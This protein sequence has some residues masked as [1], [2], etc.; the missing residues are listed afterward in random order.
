VEN[1]KNDKKNAQIFMNTPRMRIHTKGLNKTE[2]RER[3][4]KPD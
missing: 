4:R 3:E 2:V 1:G